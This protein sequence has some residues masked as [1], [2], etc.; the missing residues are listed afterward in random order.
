MRFYTTSHKHYCGIDL[1]AKSMYV[2]I[3]NQEGD[4]VLHRNMQTKPENFLRAIEP[5]RED[6]VVAVECIFTW[7]WLA[8]LCADE[9][10]HFVLGHALYIKAIHGGKAKNDRIDSLKIATILRGG[11]P[12]QAYVYPAEWRSTRDLLRRRLRFS[13]QR[14]QLLAH[15]R[16]THYQYN[17]EGPKG[18]VAYRANREGV[19]EIA[20][21][22]ERERLFR[23][24]VNTDSRA[25]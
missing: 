19:A 7:Y 5:F 10:I 24:N 25:S 17:L 23:C 11:M 22:S 2:C 6:L 1:H 15:V 13:H 20:Y 12:A 4:V 8:D 14:A 18:R 21:S 3:M 9:G 16:N